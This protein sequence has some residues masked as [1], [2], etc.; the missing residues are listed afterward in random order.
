MALNRTKY[1]FRRR[2]T[3]GAPIAHL[4]AAFGTPPIEG[5]G[6]GLAVDKPVR[7]LGRSVGTGR[8]D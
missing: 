4:R 6:S 7:R 2:V 8:R 1:L 3:L 5:D